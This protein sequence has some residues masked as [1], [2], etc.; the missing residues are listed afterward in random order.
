MVLQSLVHFLKGVG[1]SSFFFSL[2][3]DFFDL[4]NEEFIFCEDQVEDRINR[5]I[6]K[7]DCFS[8]LFIIKDK[9][10]LGIRNQ[11]IAFS[12]PT[13]SFDRVVNV[14]V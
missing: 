12:L 8:K 4:L 1:Y 6:C 10:I 13:K 11:I 3:V 7:S 2:F 9:F 14:R 5:S